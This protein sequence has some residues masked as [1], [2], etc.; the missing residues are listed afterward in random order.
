MVNLVHYL[1][2][3]EEIKKLEEFGF[4]NLIISNLNIDEVKCVYYFC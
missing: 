4:P 1:T 3:F 2:D